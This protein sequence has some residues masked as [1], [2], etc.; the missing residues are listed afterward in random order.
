MAACLMPEATSYTIIGQPRCAI[1]QPEKLDRF[2][3]VGGLARK[4]GQPAGHGDGM[5]SYWKRMV[6]VVARSKETFLTFML[7]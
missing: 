2:G 5:A 6:W 3:K 4:S 1:T 7:V